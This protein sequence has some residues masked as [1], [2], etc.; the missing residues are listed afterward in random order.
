MHAQPYVYA[1]SF[2]GLLAGLAV[3]DKVA[4][5]PIGFDSL[6]DRVWEVL[7]EPGVGAVVMSRL[8][9]MVLGI[10]TVI[11]SCRSGNILEGVAGRFEML[12]FM[13]AL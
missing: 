8:V 5:M 3:D 7:L 4:H 12:L 11:L 6:E 13:V 2:E 9:E 10:R 1:H